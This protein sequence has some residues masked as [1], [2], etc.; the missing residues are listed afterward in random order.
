M[1]AAM[2][3]ELRLLKEQLDQGLLSKEQY[4]TCSAATVAKF[5]APAAAAAAPAPAPVDRYDRSYDQAP[6]YGS[7]YSPYE[8]RSRDR[9]GKGGKKGL[10]PSSALDRGEKGGKK[11]GGKSLG[12]GAKGEPT[13]AVVKQVCMKNRR[14]FDENVDRHEAYNSPEGQQLLERFTKV[15]EAYEGDMLLPVAV[16]EVCS[17]GEDR[18]NTEALLGSLCPQAF[19]QFINQSGTLS[20]VKEL[21]PDTYQQQYYLTSTPAAAAESIVAV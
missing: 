12:K 8:P 21:R 10:I 13:G 15:L 4:D 18:K 20:C 3:E 6:D 16:G 5:T 19:M 14:V 17:T 11:G 7:S 1:A 2:G 9:G